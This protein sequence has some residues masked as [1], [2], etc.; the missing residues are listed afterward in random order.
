M[1]DVTHAVWPC[2]WEGRVAG[3]GGAGPRILPLTFRRTQRVPTP[4]SRSRADEAVLRLLADVA[5][6]STAVDWHRW[7]TSRHE[8]ALADLLRGGAPMVGA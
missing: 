1:R 3:A 6:S 2:G 5:R 4:A 8:E 7:I